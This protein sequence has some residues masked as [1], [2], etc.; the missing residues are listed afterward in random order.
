AGWRS[1][2]KPA[3]RRAQRIESEGVFDIGKQQFLM[4]LFVMEAERCPG[5]DFRPLRSRRGLDQL[6]HPE[7]DVLSVAVHL[8]YRG[9]GEQAAGVARKE[10]THCL[11]IG[12]EQI[13][14]RGMERP[15]CRTEPTQQKSL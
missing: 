12:I 15:I 5:R 14:V 4:L 8:V 7:I 13:S 2:P 6:A 3:I 1:L 9:S 10:R 11:V